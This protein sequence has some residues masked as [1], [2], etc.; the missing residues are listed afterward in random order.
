MIWGA[1]IGGTIGVAF[2]A[3]RSGGTMMLQDAQAGIRFV[4]I[5]AIL[6]AVTP[7]AIGAFI[8]WILS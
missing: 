6:H 1:L 4:V 3:F 8:G 5:Q 2:Y 7:A